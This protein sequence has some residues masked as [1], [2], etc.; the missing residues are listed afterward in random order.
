MLEHWEDHKEGVCSCCGNDTENN[1]RIRVVGCFSL[2]YT[3]Y[4]CKQH[5]ERFSINGQFFVKINGELFWEWNAEYGIFNHL[6][7]VNS[8]EEY[9]HL[10]DNEEAV[11]LS[12]VRF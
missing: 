5:I 8:F 10:R 6:Q 9:K 2:C 1:V 4:L 12:D 3:V 11:F 7:K